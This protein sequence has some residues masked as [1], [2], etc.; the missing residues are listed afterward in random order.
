ML[1]PNSNQTT[2]FIKVYGYKR[3]RVVIFK[4]RKTGLLKEL[5]SLNKLNNQ[6]Q[7]VF[8][9]R[10]NAF[11]LRFCVILIRKTKVYIVLSCSL[12]P[13][14]L[15]LFCF[16]LFFTITVTPT[17]GL[18]RLYRVE[19]ERILAKFISYVQ[20]CGV[21]LDNRKVPLNTRSFDQ[22]FWALCLSFNKRYI[23][24]KY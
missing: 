17:R 13:P 22:T 4:L 1:T 8:V 15:Y 5:L 14:D 18:P 6:F 3:T 10:I 20:A 12:I 11:L 16:F 19:A 23:Y 21:W 9:K 7:R 2:R 24:Y